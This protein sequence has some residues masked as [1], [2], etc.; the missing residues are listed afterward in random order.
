MVTL[1]MA[2]EVENSVSLVD[3]RMGIQ[4][5]NLILETLPLGL[6]TRGIKGRVRVILLVNQAKVC[7]G[8]LYVSFDIQAPATLQIYRLT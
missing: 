8:L 2:T 4:S 6:G 5:A 7:R 1:T 3:L